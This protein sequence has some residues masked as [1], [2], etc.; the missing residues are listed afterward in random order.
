MATKKR[1]AR[2]LKVKPEE[3]RLSRWDSAD[4]LR[5]EQNIAEYFDAALAEGGDDPIYMLQVLGTIARARGMMKLASE[6]GLTRAGL[7]K[8]LA[9]NAKPSIQTVHKI[10]KALGFRL[11]FTHAV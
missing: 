3:L 5:T 7:Y 10:A 4:Y 8:A 9:P 11:T 2:H 6:S 1:T